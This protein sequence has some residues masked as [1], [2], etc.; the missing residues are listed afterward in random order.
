MSKIEAPC[1][2]AGAEG[3][4]HG[5]LSKARSRRRN[6]RGL[7]GSRRMCGLER[8]G[9]AALRQPRDLVTNSDSPLVTNRVTGARRVTRGAVPE[10]E[11]PA[12]GAS[13]AGTGENFFGAGRGMKLVTVC[14]EV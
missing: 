7:G 2:A 9:R 10:G 6:F 3:E 4:N 12:A 11:K 8:R 13:R 1:S 14:V 5:F